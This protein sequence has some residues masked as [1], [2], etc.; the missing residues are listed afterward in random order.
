M[1]FSSPPSLDNPTFGVVPS[2]QTECWRLFPHGLQCHHTFS[3]AKGKPWGAT[4]GFVGV[5]N[6]IGCKN[7]VLEGL[8]VCSE[9]VV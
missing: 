4:V 7:M 9:L 2:K 6:T 1:C 5:S 8:R 3:S